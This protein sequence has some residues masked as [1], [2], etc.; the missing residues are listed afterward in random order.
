VKY[1]LIFFT[2]PFNFQLSAFWKKMGVWSLGR[3]GY[4][5]EAV[6]N[7]RGQI[8]LPM[9]MVKAGMTGTRWW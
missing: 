6:H 9:G 8:A 2:T 7:R 3:K 5:R 4:V 1:L